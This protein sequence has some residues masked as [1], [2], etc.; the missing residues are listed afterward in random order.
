MESIEIL[1]KINGI[2]ATVLEN[3][4]IMLTREST[5]TTVEGWDSYTHIRLILTIEKY[6]HI[7]FNTFEIQSWRNIGDLCDAIQQKLLSESGK[8]TS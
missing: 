7:H 8:A 6:F 2:F 5:V 3:R 4:Q 1:N